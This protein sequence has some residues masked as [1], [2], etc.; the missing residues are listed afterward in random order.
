MAQFSSADREWFATASVQEQ[1]T[2]PQIPASR[3][4]ASQQQQQKG[5]RKRPDEFD[6]DA[7]RNDPDVYAFIRGKRQQL[8]PMAS[9]KENKN[10]DI[11]RA[12][13]RDR[14]LAS[15]A[16]RDLMEIRA[17]LD[18]KAEI[19]RK[20]KEHKDI[21][22]LGAMV[23]NLRKVETLDLQT[24]YRVVAPG[25]PHPERIFDLEL[26]TQH[27][28]KVESS[29]SDISDSE[30]SDGEVQENAELSTLVKIAQSTARRLP[31]VEINPVIRRSQCFH[32]LMNMRQSIDDW[33]W[34]C[35]LLD[36]ANTRNLRSSAFREECAA[37]S[38]KVYESA[39]L[40][41]DKGVRML[42][43][44]W[45]SVD[46]FANLLRAWLLANPEQV[47]NEFIREIVGYLGLL[48]FHRNAD[49]AAN[50]KL[51]AICA[52]P[53][54]HPSDVK[55]T[56]LYQ[57][58]REE[59]V[60]AF[61][62]P[63]EFDFFAC[64]SENY[65]SNG[66]KAF[67][68]AQRRKEEDLE[69]AMI[70]KLP[71]LPKR[72]GKN[73]YEAPLPKTAYVRRCVEA[74][75]ILVSAISTIYGGNT[76]QIRRAIEFMMYCGSL[77]RLCRG[78][79]TLLKFQTPAAE[80]L[81]IA[82]SV[83]P[84]IEI[85]RILQQA[86][87]V[88]KATGATETTILGGF[89]RSDRIKMIDFVLDFL[90]EAQFPSLDWVERR[91]QA[92]PSGAWFTG[93]SSTIT[94][95]DAD[96]SFAVAGAISRDGLLMIDKDGTGRGC[97]IEGDS[98]SESICSDYSVIEITNY[99][100]D[101]HAKPARVCSSW[102]KSYDPKDPETPPRCTTR[103]CRSLHP[104]LRLDGLCKDWTH[105]QCNDVDCD[106]AHDD[107]L[108]PRNMHVASTHPRNFAYRFK[109]HIPYKPHTIGAKSQF[110]NTPS[111]IAKGPNLM[112]QRNQ[113]GLPTQM[114]A[115]VGSNMFVNPDMVQSATPEMLAAAMGQAYFNSLSNF[116]PTPGQFYGTPNSNGLTG[117]YGAQPFPT[118][119]GQQQHN[120]TNQAGPVCYYCRGTGHV[121]KFYYEDHEN[122][123]PN[124][125][126][127]VRAYNNESTN[128]STA[129]SAISSPLTPLEN[130]GE[131]RVRGAANS[132][133]P[134]YNQSQRP[135][136][137]TPR[138]NRLNRNRPEQNRYRGP[139]HP[140]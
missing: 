69:W 47:N 132:T 67:M 105:N 43:L 124:T 131:L 60:V 35:S 38:E 139:Q 116:F 109:R 33:A 85:L 95:G 123:G 99:R 57:L 34:L 27:Q 76:S 91:L 134:A 8:R 107:P 125:P 113:Y 68:Q 93:S 9:E 84:L 127:G 56:S 89:K 7:W 26:M 92:A 20:Q 120:V 41:D 19:A 119:F 44:P 80:F 100:E 114:P 79:Y 103:F 73:I 78:F 4:S 61:R 96:V 83:R 2:G 14:V 6:E 64:R 32:V 118:P 88:E 66:D 40:S 126:K 15:Q 48:N 140:R 50:T 39:L 130:V 70:Q 81:A 138:D 115:V 74:L 75:R 31:A 25:L 24:F 94:N 49:T 59:A 110:A 3:F 37:W 53:R 87:A 22:A 21:D 28:P 90:V 137:R 46:R 45:S 86:K 77:L 117:A 104:D 106:L 18:M 51:K 52:A 129:E 30:P 17:S 135:P 97:L 121:Q 65:C 54:N 63:N 98:D 12:S 55:D 101:P 58:L 10:A 11:S 112:R 82:D 16:L 71:T 108:Y 62:S 29:E 42:G 133:R 102:V 122:R 5:K 136:N 72:V 111:G 36:T 23:T 13:I 1:E 128:L